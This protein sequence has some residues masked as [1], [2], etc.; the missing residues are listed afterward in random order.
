MNWK[1]SSVV[2]AVLVI[3]LLVDVCLGE[4]VSLKF[5]RCWE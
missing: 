2:A 1:V 4:K 5:P 3:L